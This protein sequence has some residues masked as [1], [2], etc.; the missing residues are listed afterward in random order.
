M[1]TFPLECMEIDVGNTKD[2]NDRCR[3]LLGSSVPS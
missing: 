3:L 1:K 2:D